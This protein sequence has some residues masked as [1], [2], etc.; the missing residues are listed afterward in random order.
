MALAARAGYHAFTLPPA[1]RCVGGDC[2]AAAQPSPL[3]A[4]GNS[5]W[6]CPPCAKYAAVRSMAAYLVHCDTIR[7]GKGLPAWARSAHTKFTAAGGRITGRAGK[8]V[9]I[10]T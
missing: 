5:Y 7:G 3:V 2:T 10:A 6:V 1:G 9:I 8:S 4:T